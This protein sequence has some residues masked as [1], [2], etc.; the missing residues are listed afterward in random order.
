MRIAVLH[1][2][3]FRSDSAGV[4]LE[5]KPDRRVHVGAKIDHEPARERGFVAE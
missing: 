5:L 2:N 1:R 4:A 3:Q